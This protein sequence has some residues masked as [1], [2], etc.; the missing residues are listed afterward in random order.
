MQRTALTPLL[1]GL[2]L[3]LSSCYSKD[4]KEPAAKNLERYDTRRTYAASYNAVWESLLQVLKETPLL[5]VKKEN[6]LLITDWIMT[7]S[8][9][10]YSGY[11][12]TK[13]PIKVRY[14]LTIT[15]RPLETATAVQIDND[16]QYW[17]DA[18]SAGGEFTGSLYQWVDTPSSTI[19]ER[20]LLDNLSDALAQAHPPS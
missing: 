12:D 11:D 5:V 15:V 20:A 9:R 19:K 7:K 2:I 6:G 10:L 14:K 16:E 18:I 3:L 17:A 8:D 1:F 4:F 13:I